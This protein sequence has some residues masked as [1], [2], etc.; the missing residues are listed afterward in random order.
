AYIRPSAAWD[1]LRGVAHKTRETILLC[2]AAGYDMI[3]VETV[4]VGQSETAV[5]SM[6]DFF[7][8]LL[9]P[10]AGDELQGIKRGVMEMADLIAVNKADGDRLLAAKKAKQSYQNAVHLFP[11]K[12]N[13]WL[14]KVMLCSALE[15]S[16][17]EG[18]SELLDQYT[19]DMKASGFFETH[20]STQSRYWMF[21]YVNA[22]LKH[23]FFNHPEIL[24]N[25]EDIEQQVLSGAM[26]SFKAGDQLLD[27]F[28]AKND[29]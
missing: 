4:G 3:I 2:E 28:N 18:I 12:D 14:V 20:R 15:N 25:L 22:R 26:S 29:T 21:E 10:G 6:V 17:I 1:S 8:L 19:A 11:A 9:L 27:L 7:L 16:G 5:H 13:N 24:K 23:Q